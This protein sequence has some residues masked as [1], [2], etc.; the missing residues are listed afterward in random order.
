MLLLTLLTTIAIIKIKLKS[1]S[2]KTLTMRLIGGAAGSHRQYVVGDRI[3]GS[4]TCGNA[5]TILGVQ[6]TVFEGLDLATCERVAIKMIAH[7]YFPDVASADH[8]SRPKCTN[9]YP[10][11]Q[12][13]APNIP[14]RSYGGD[15]LLKLQS[16]LHEIKVTSILK[17]S[18]HVVNIR[19]VVV[20]SFKRTSNIGYSDFPREA[21]P[22][23]VEEYIF[24]IME[25]CMDSI[26]SIFFKLTQSIPCHS[27]VP[28]FVNF[29]LRNRLTLSQRN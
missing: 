25:F 18:K 9:C 23:Q 21:L 5:P 2:I 11:M 26:D 1:I 28:Y 10:F 8:Q 22:H 6:G 15:H 24:I 27:K 12:L 17:A 16:I 14:R 19:D 29:M 13:S 3:L 20:E 7:K 4:G